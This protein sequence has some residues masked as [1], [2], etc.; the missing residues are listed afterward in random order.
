MDK[1]VKFWGSL[2]GAMISTLLLAT[3]LSQPV[4][5]AEV[6]PLEQRVT[7]LEA[8]RVE[9]VKRLDEIRNDV[10]ELLSRVPPRP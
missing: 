2:A 6:R 1:G 9:D 8:Q 7:R 10:K 3:Y 5:A 4:A